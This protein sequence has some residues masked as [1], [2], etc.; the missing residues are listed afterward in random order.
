MKYSLI[1]IISTTLLL[2]G[3]GETNDN[4]KDKIEADVV[5]NVQLNSSDYESLY[6][7]DKLQLDKIKDELSQFGQHLDYADS[8][9]VNIYSYGNNYIISFP[10]G[11]SIGQAAFLASSMNYGFCISKHNNNSLKDLIIYR[12]EEI[13]VND[14]VAVSQRDENL[15]FKINIVTASFG[16]LDNNCYEYKTKPNVLSK[17][18]NVLP[19]DFKITDA[20]LIEK[21]YNL[22]RFKGFTPYVDSSKLSSKSTTI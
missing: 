20:Q 15:S 4:I 17:Y 19:I 16:G 6:I 14:F 10:N 22:K 2:I 11:L 3:C 18:N 12:D 8:L 13:L 1:K 21:R 9:V 5:K 7:C